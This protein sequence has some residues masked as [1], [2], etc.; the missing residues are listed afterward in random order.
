MENLYLEDRLKKIEVIV[1]EIDGVVTEHLSSIDPL[2]VTIFKEYC[3]KDF[4]AVNE[5]KKTFNFVFIS[6]DQN[7]NFNVCRNRNIKAFFGQKIKKKKQ[8]LVDI[9]RTYNTTPEGIL[10]VGNSY[11]DLECMRMVPLTFCPSDAV[12]SV[13]E[14]ASCTLACASGMG[15]LCE[16]YELI[17]PEIIRRKRE[18]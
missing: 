12:R 7:I 5:F 11:S 13:T 8:L 3:M 17:R 9:M 18:D 2:G 4:E 10:Y 1:S 6:L 15:V 14:V 16:L